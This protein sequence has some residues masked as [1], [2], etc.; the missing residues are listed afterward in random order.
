VAIAYATLEYVVSHIGCFTLFVTHYPVLSQLEHVF[1]GA[2][3]NYHM[4]FF[5]EEQ[6]A[7]HGNDKGK[8][9]E[10]E[11]EKGGGDGMDVDEEEQLRAAPLPKYPFPPHLVQSE[12]TNWFIIIKYKKKKPEKKK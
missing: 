6:P 4:A 9:K 10:K 7:A 11:K 8:E 12:Q 1:P 5:E 2:V 3:G